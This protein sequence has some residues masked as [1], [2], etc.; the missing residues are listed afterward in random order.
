MENLILLLLRHMGTPISY[1]VQYMLY[2]KY[3]ILTAVKG[4]V[5][6]KTDV[7]YGRAAT[8]QLHRKLISHL[9]K[10]HLSGLLSLMK[11]I[12]NPFPQE[13]F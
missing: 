2:L 8:T 6:E 13:N 10:A 3:C 7:S 4:K 11:N 5:T 9:L 12:T 1:Y